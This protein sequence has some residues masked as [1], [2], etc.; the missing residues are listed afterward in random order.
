VSFE[1]YK[2]KLSQIIISIPFIPSAATTIEF[3]I[4]IVCSAY[5]IVLL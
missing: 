3:K 5:S 2:I 4:V 1:I